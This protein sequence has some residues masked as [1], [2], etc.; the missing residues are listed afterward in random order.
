MSWIEVVSTTGAGACTFDSWTAHT[1]SSGWK[2]SG[3]T[4]SLVTALTLTY[5][6]NRS[7]QW[8]GAKQAPGIT[9]SVIT[10]G[11]TARPRRDSISTW[12][13]SVI[14]RAAASAGLISTNGAGLSLFSLATLPVLVIVCHWCWRRPV[15]ST[16][17]KSSS[18][19]SAG[20][21]CGRA[22]KIAFPLAVANRKPPSPVR[23]RIGF[24]AGP[25]TAAGHCT[26]PSASRW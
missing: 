8:N 4:A 20:S 14:P 1:L 23:Y 26:G 7:F 13:P 24:R 2:L 15:F 11:S 22:W 5:S 25:S 16:N 9:R 19:S 17:G 6:P 21:R 12:S 10:A 3:S 18:G